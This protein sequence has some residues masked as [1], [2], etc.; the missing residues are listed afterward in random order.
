MDGIGYAN[1]FYLVL[2]LS[3]APAILNNSMSDPLKH[4]CGVSLLRLRKPMAYYAERYGTGYYGYE[5]MS[6]LLEKQ[7]NRGQ[8]GA[9]IACVGLEVD[10]SGDV[11]FR[12][13]QNF[14]S[15]SAKPS[16]LAYITKNE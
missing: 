1:I 9:G 3:P 4:E 12:K 5:K 14:T 15:E 7:H 16:T 11:A 8:D 6:L 13:I 10:G 2:F